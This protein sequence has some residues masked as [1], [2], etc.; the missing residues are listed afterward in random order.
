MLRDDLLTISQ[1]AVE[2]VLPENV[3]KNSV[4]FKN[5]LLSVGIHQFNL[6]KY[7]RIVLLGSGKASIKMAETL[8]ATLTGVDVEGMVVCNYAGSIDGIDVVQG[9]HPVPDE[10]SLMA[11]EKMI[12]YL[13]SLNSDDLVI[14]LLSGGSSAL[15]EMPESSLT[16]QD[17]IDAT[18]SLLSSGMP[19][20]AVN[21]LRQRLSR[22]KGGKLKSY[23]KADGVVLV[24]SDVMGDPLSFI[25]SGPMVAPADEFD[26]EEL[27]ESYD[28]AHKLSSKI[29]ETLKKSIPMSDDYYPHVLIGNNRV[30]LIAAKKAAEERDYNTIIM[31]TTM[32][33]EASEVAKVLSSIL[34]EA[35]NSAGD[36]KT[37]VCLLFGGET[38]VTIKGSGKG[39][40][41]QEMV[42]AMVDA[43]KNEHHF[44]AGSI[45]T[46]GIDG[47]SDAAGAFVDE[48]VIKEME[49]LSLSAKSYLSNNDSN[50]FFNK[51]GGVITMGPTGTNVCDVVILLAGK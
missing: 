16:L 15:M 42:L 24:L 25:G 27:I 9:A 41:N 38:T 34:K 33:G 3:I 47:M 1:S 37:P 51:T 6:K 13:K 22:V 50:T 45:G 10:K 29:L 14:Y 19:I 12:T 46:D 4:H 43:L 28:L 39:G 30:A 7:N 11:A 44:C 8:K 5:N 40:R 32:T 31:S 17:N 20:E 2:A 36:L 35:V 26:V 49:T 21:T 23:S 18:K 48:Q